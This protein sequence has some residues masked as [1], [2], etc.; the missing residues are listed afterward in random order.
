MRLRTANVNVLT[1]GLRLYCP[2]SH[3]SS[4]STCG[5][6]GEAGSKRLFRGNRIQTAYD[7]DNSV[8]RLY[9]RVQIPGLEIL[10]DGVT[11]GGDRKSVH[12]FQA[13]VLA[14]A[15]SLSRRHTE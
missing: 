8:A 7:F 3:S 2:V 15:T 6:A 1:S 9:D 11:K 14:T 5:I 10:E 13:R 4:I 12:I